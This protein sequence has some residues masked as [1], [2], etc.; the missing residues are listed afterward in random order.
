MKAKPMKTNPTRS[1]SLWF[2]LASALFVTACA[3]L[4]PASPETRVAYARARTRRAAAAV[5]EQ[6]KPTPEALPTV[7]GRAVYDDTS[8]PVRRAR[9]MLVSDV[10]AR[11]DFNALT[12]G[13]GDFHIEGVRA[14]SYFAFVDVPGVLSPVGFVSVGELRGGA[15]ELGEA[16]QFFDSVEVAGKEDVRVTVHAR[17]GAVLGGKVSYADG[18]PAVNVT[19]NLMRRGSDGRLAKYLSGAGLVSLSG[20]RTDDRGVFRI[21]G[22]P[23]G[24]YF[25]GVTES[26]DHGDSGVARSGGNDIAGM[27]EGLMGQQLLMTFYPSATNSKDASSVKVAAGEERGDID[28][29]IPERELRTLE[30][31][32][33]GRRDKQPVANARVTIL[34]KED[35]ASAAGREA[36]YLSGGE[37][38]QNVTTTDADGRW[39]FREIPD[40]PYTLFIRPPEEYESVEGA[41]TNRNAPI[42]NANVTISST[43]GNMNGAFNPPRKKKG[44]AP[45][46]QEVEVSGDVSEVEVEVSDG[47]RISGTITVEGGRPSQYSYVNVMRA[48][49]GAAESGGMD[50]KSTTAYSGRFSVEGLPA[51]R[52]FIQPNTYDDQGRVYVKSIT[53]NGKDL[54]REPLELGD[55]ANADGIEIVFSR[56][57]A[58]LR[59]RATLDGGKATASN[60][61]VYLMPALGAPAAEPSAQQLFCTTGSD[62]FCSIN[63]A[64]GEYVVVLMP[65]S[66]ARTLVGEELRR[67]FNAAPR[68]SLRVG[69]TK[70][71]EV[72]VPEK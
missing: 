64:P 49:E 6:A 42:A 46:R 4:T 70:E 53:W 60:A 26:V 15:H 34:R 71:L 18:D 19:I 3:C 61:F 24:E 39:R 12:D 28:V 63:A 65:Q 5:Q 16:R 50:V 62:G 33:R 29:T 44:Y 31:V 23:P 25:V 9:V 67:R 43:S 59:V 35:A 13:R 22:L 20:L 69:E 57:P 7:Y 58:I 66:G 45:T 72:S 10:G 54:A 30:G 37:L 38:S 14:G 40:G 47:G 68:V 21:T 2:A 32:V 36:A 1:L 56:N 48:A 8:R 51:G 27:L 52:F 55:G 41:T 11:T 17:R